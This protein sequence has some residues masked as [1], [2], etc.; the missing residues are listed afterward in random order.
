MLKYLRNIV[1]INIVKGGGG[2][3]KHLAGKVTTV[4]P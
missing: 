3:G 1:P 4:N 2:G